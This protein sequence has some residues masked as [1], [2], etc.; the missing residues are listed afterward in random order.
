MERGTGLIL[1]S[2]HVSN[3]EWLCIG[4]PKSLGITLTAIIHPMHNPR[5]DD[6]VEG[7]RSMH[8]NRVVPLGVAIRDIIRSLRSNRTVALLADQSGPSGALYVKFFGRYAATYEGPAMFA[9]RT[10]AP[11]VMGFSVRQEDGTYEVEFEEMKTDDLTDGSQEDIQELTRRH[12]RCLERAI[13]RHP[14]SWLWQHKRW[15]HEPGPG[16]ILIDDPTDE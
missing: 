4:V 6:L 3:W 13:R 10:G 1:M 2:G 7:Y 9:L 11:L 12:V 5:V 15:K 8:G 14:E 16:S